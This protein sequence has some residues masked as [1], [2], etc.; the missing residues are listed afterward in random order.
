MQ[1]C[2]DSEFYIR[3]NS[4]III[5]FYFWQVID[6]SGSN[7]SGSVQLVGGGLDE[8]F[9]EFKFSSFIG[10]PLKYVI[11]VYTD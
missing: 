3:T 9:A 7:S 10:G 11:Q 1:L 6:V 5:L 2:I 4:L 8:R